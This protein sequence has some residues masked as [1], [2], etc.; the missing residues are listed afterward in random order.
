MLCEAVVEDSQEKLIPLS[1]PVIMELLKFCP[2]I[3]NDHIPPEPE[4]SATELFLSSM[5][6]IAGTSHRHCASFVPTGALQ[7]LR[8]VNQL[9]LL[10]SLSFSPCA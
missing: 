7:M 4:Y 5:K 3:L 9:Q 2:Q 1:D 10:P 8:Q 6:A